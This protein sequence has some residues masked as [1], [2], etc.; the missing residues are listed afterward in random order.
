[1]KHPVK[2]FTGIEGNIPR[3]EPCDEFIQR[4]EVYGI[5]IILVEVPVARIDVGHVMATI[6]ITQVTQS[7]ILAFV[8][9]AHRCRELINH[10]I[11][12]DC[13]GIGNIFV[14]PRK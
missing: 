3:V 10:V 6:S 1:M 14:T 4:G 7:A 11:D 5:D 9:L 12:G 13:A 8:F 2:H